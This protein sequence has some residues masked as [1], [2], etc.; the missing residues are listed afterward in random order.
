MCLVCVCLI[1]KKADNRY[2]IIFISEEREENHFTIALL[3]P[4][5]LL[6][7]F[8]SLKLLIPSSSSKTKLT[9]L[10]SSSPSMQTK[11]HGWASVG[12]GVIAL[13]LLVS[14]C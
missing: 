1:F 11:I 5:F 10:Q 2:K 7:P 4:L 9:P 6:F 12:F 13:L 3:L 8:S 14:A